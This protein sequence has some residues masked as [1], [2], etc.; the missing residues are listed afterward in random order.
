MDC[1]YCDGFFGF[2]SL[3][4]VCIVPGMIMPGFLGRA[5]LYESA[6]VECFVYDSR[7]TSSSFIVEHFIAIA[8]IAS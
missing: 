1:D 8:F 7:D 6:P 2:F 3:T 4:S 5:M